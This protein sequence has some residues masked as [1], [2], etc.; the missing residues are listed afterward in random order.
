[1]ARFRALTKEAPEEPGVYLMKDAEGAIIYVGKAKVLRNRLS[2]YFSGRKDVKTRHL[3]ARVDAIEWIIAASE[4]DALILENNLIKQHSPRYN[5]NLKDGK[6]YPSVRV[7]NEAFP[8]VFRTRR[9]VDDGSQYFG[10][11]PSA[12]TIDTYLEMIKR[13]FP[14]R[15]CVDLRKHK[16]ACMYWHI[17]RCSAPCIDKISE[18]E[19]AV[20]VDEVRKLLSGDT[21]ALLA[22]LRE[23]MVAASIALKF[24]EAAR[25]RDAIRAIDEF[26]GRAGTEDKDPE[27]RDY[28]AWAAD[29]ELVSF[30]VFQ[31]RLGRMTGRDLYRTRVASDE[32][33]AL[34]DFLMSYY[35]PDRPPPAKI[36]VQSKGGEG[37]GDLDLVLAWFERQLGAAS[38]ILSPGDLPGERRHGATIA[39]AAQNAREDLA[40]RRREMGDPAA[41][42]ALKEALG[43]SHIPER[44]EGFDIAQLSGKHTVSSLVS[45][46]N[47]IPD[48]KNYRIFKIKSL[49][50]AID[51]FASIRE[52]V[53]RRYTKLVN[54]DAELP[55]LVLV[56]GG[57]GQVSAAKEILDSLGLDC[58]LAGLA[59]REEEVWLP[60]RAEPVVLPH[61]SP[62]L[63]V[64]V[65]V[66]DETHRFATGHN[67]RL[68]AAELKFG[69]LESIEGVGP[70][71]A[72]RLLRAF[73]SLEVLGKAGVDDIA[74]AGKLGKAVAERLKAALAAREK[75]LGSSGEVEAGPTAPGRAAERGPGWAA[76]KSS[77]PDLPSE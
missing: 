56:D 9:I 19:Y 16:E 58:D 43:L 59:K 69:I 17:G 10:P 11:F 5:I 2:S 1:M 38:A 18:S 14:L 21:E 36:F 45:F 44:I 73:G 49:E 55:D 15:R 37:R 72:K 35:G 31:M 63:R 70:E 47:G 39:L 40:K 12:D 67:Q 64:L 62:A 74:G 26:R 54:E 51:D 29:G 41:L 4:Y 46:K 33:E 30:I 57:K 24:E 34:V 71:R 52:A 25:L 23:R 53:A 6:T 28:I 75:G 27:G 3:V 20:H 32:S 65:A 68:R 48:K 61:D 77:K 13:L 50:G 7:T 42:A 8:R 22:S 66:R 76:E 60:N